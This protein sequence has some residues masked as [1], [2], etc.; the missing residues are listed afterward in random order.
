MYFRIRCQ[1]YREDEDKG[2]SCKRH[3]ESGV[4]LCDPANAVTAK[5]F[6]TMDALT[7]MTHKLAV[8]LS[9]YVVLLVQIW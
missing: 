1:S 3:T 7:N 5:E 9:L 6:S 2:K 4:K 8:N